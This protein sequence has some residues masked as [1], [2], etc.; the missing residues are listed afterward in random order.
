MVSGAAELIRENGVAG[1]TLDDVRA[2]TGTSK[3]QI[4]HYFPDGREE[5]LLAVAQHEATRVLDDQRPHLDR[6]STWAEWS[7]WRDVVVA[8]YRRQGPQCPLHALTSHI[9][10]GTPGARAVVQQL[11]SDWE[12]PLRDGIVSMQTSGELDADLVADQYAR[13]ILASVQGGVQI[14]MATGSSEHLENALDLVLDA[15]RSRRPQA[16]GKTRQTA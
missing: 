15:M 8:R 12:R 10:S 7:A 5:L 4:F 14:L 2:R 13:A 9:G 3:S 16:S 6:L 11:M 1:T